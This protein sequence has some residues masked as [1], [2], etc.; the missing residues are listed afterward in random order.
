LGS[1]K[2]WRRKLDDSWITPFSIDGKRW[3]SVEHYFLASQFKKGFPDFY[4]K[5]SVESGT[6]ISK[7][8]E[9]ARIAGSK[10]GKVKDRILRES[11]ITMDPDFYTL[12]TNPI[13]EVERAKALKAKFSGN[14]ELK[15][16][17]LETKDAKLVHFQ[18]SK[19]HIAD[20][21]LMKVR[22]ELQ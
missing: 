17:L 9:L 7:D 2:D 6:D 18:R 8:I 15:N 11:K 22:N 3:N 1:I 10:S 20:T 16:M 21:M 5:F 13:F 14:L 19:G 12:G 4:L